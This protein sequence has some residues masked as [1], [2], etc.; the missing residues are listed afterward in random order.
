ML[1]T[2]LYHARRDLDAERL[3]ALK[4]RLDPALLRATLRPFAGEARD[5]TLEACGRVVAHVEGEHGPAI[6]E[7]RAILER[8]FHFW[9]IGW[10]P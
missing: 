9:T 6:H 10:R 3:E 8:L 1:A 2:N 7:A 4:T 5:V